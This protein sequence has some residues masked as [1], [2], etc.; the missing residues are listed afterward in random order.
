MYAERKQKVEPSGLLVI[1]IFVF[2][3]ALFMAF[4]SASETEDPSVIAIVLAIIAMTICISGSL[5]Y[6]AKLNRYE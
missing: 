3:I 1:G 5:I 6:T 2:L 4:E